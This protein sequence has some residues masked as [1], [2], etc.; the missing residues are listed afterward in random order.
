MKLTKD[1]DDDDSNR[2]NPSNTIDSSQGSIRKMAKFLGRDAEKL[3]E[4]EE[5]FQKI[6][7]NSTAGEMRKDQERW[8]PKDFR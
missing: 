6:L 4:D 1:D 3:I 5:M 7:F 8:F 2:I